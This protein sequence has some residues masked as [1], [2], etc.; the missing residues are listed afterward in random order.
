LL[1]IIIK[2][3]I[4]SISNIFTK[5]DL[6]NFSKYQY[7][8]IFDA[9]I[10][11]KTLFK[12]NKFDECLYNTI[13]LSYNN[14]SY[15]NDKFNS[16]NFLN[17]SVTLEKV[18]LKVNMVYSFYSTF[19]QS[20]SS[21]LDIRINNKNGSFHSYDFII[22]P[23]NLYY[24]ILEQEKFPFYKEG[25]TTSYQLVELIED[26]DWIFSNYKIWNIMQMGTWS[27]ISLTNT[28]KDYLDYFSFTISKKVKSQTR[29]YK[30]IQNVLAEIGG[31]FSTLIVIGNFLLSKFNQT[32]CEINIINHLFS[33]NFKIKENLEKVEKSSLN[34]NAKSIINILE[35]HNKNKILSELE[36]KTSYNTK[37]P[38][39]FIINNDPNMY[40]NP[41][42]DPFRYENN[43]NR[44]LIE[45]NTYNKK[46][47]KNSKISPVI[48]DITSSNKDISFIDKFSFIQ[49]QNNNENL[50]KET[51]SLFLK[52]EKNKQKNNPLIRFSEFEILKFFFCCKRFKY[53]DFLKQE[54]FYAQAGKKI[55][56]Y[57][58]VIKHMKL[59]ENFENLKSLI[60]NKHQIYAF[61]FFKKRD[62]REI[63]LSKEENLLELFKYFMDKDTFSRSKNIIPDNKIIFLLNQDLKNLFNI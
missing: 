59:F 40:K 5:N 49:K 12:Y 52:E 43:S 2:T 46:Q 39:N 31:I 29:V 25:W 61:D 33:D 57:L 36:S 63:N 3:I 38:I 17:Q 50:S 28:F 20:N 26:S 18:L 16:K 45:L 35:D 23:D 22:D 51:I 54:E 37:K 24:G 27:E 8:I 42:N 9:I 11:Q 58:D 13:L 41:N 7:N 60:L 55:I 1:K 56:R 44:K 30:K 14:C 15:E 19:Y 32:T 34:N 62:L 10:N 48:N 53:A 6:N 21:D 47:N 4:E